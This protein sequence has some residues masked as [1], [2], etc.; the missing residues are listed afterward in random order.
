MNHKPSVYTIIFLILALLSAVTITASAKDVSLTRVS[1]AWD[2]SQTDGS[3]WVSVI[4]ADARF[5][6]YVAD[7]GNVVQNG[8][9]GTQNVYLYD[10]KSV[11]NELVSVASD[12]GPANGDSYGPAISSDGRY[13]AFTSTANNIDDNR[14]VGD[15]QVYVRDRKT[16]QTKIISL[17]LNGAAPDECAGDPSISGTGRY[18][19]FRSFASNLIPGDGDQMADIYVRDTLKNTFFLVSKSS[20]GE[21]GNDDSG[22]FG[23]PAI[24]S[25]GRYV[26]FQS[27]STNLVKGDTNGVS[28]IFLNDRSTGKTIRISVSSNGNQSNGGSV[29]PAISGNGRY[30]AFLSDATN[31][32]SGDTNGKNDVFVYDRVTKKMERVSVSS[33]GKQGDG[34]SVSNSASTKVSLSWDGRYVVFTSQASNLAPGGVSNTCN[35]QSLSTPGTGTSP[36]FNIYIKDRKTGKTTRVTSAK[37][38]G[39]VNGDSLMPSMSHNGNWVTFVSAADNMIPND[40]NGLLDI[41]VY[42]QP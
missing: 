23:G 22:V 16:G 2:G 29:F 33:S 40:T 32:V 30:I 7:A 3:S 37:D 8:T 36:C 34:D 26:A 15:Q 14:G 19:A 9:K 38:G 24:S 41:F 28:D 4:S 13:V 42:H 27:Y 1:M 5:V 31:L 10:Q 21:K 6:A 11:K 20:S 35:S 18:V 17:P 12:G 39:L 25:D